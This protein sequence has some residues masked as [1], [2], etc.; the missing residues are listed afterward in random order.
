MPVVACPNCTK[1][2]RIPDTLKAG[3]AVRCPLCQKPFV[4]TVAP[5]LPPEPEPVVQLEETDLVPSPRP[6][7]PRAAPRAAARR[8]AADPFAFDE[9]PAADPSRGTGDGPAPADRRKGNRGPLI[10]IMGIMG[11][12]SLPAPVVGLVLLVQS[13]ALSRR[14]DSSPIALLCAFLGLGI[15]LC[16]LLLGYFARAMAAE[17]LRRI[18]Y[19]K[20]N[21]QGKGLIVGGQVCGLIAVIGS[22]LIL[23][24]GL[25]GVLFLA[26]RLS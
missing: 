7:A 2:I 15:A 19:Q 21:T 26:L 16:P 18:A 12:T 22:A 13:Y 20:V 9:P 24:L 1:N 4:P 14:F 3:A 6:P 10:L 25:V 17:E 11:I 23:G 8:T 5:P